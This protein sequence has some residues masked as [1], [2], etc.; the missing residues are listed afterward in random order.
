MT[1]HMLTDE[2]IA[3]IAAAASK[4]TFEDFFGQFGYDLTDT[5]GRETLRDDLRYLRD[6]RQGSEELRD[7]IKNSF[8][9]I[10]PVVT[11]GTATWFFY[12]FS[13]GLRQAIAVWLSK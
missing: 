13:D 6:Q 10:V 9:T 1:N 11:L 12:A 2:Q 4:K 8:W 7:R 5:R 3:A